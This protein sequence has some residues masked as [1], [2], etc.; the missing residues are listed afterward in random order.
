MQKSLIISLLLNIALLATVLYLYKHQP[1]KSMRDDKECV[2]SWNNCIKKL[3]MQADVVFFGDS[4]TAYGDWQRAFP[5][6]KSINL[7]YMGEDTK[8]MLRR[9]E[10][11][12]SVHPRKVFLMAGLNGLGDQTAD[13]FESAYCTLVDSIL[14]AV[15][16]AELYIENILPVN[17]DVYLNKKVIEA[18]RIIQKIA[19]ERKLTYVDLYSL[20]AVNCEQPTDATNDGVH[21]KSEAY[22]LWYE[23]LK[24][25]ISKR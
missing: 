24:E 22:D 12:Q 8:G 10:V 20:Y 18:N 16:D 25:L 6:I 3:D 13:G 2:M 1:N 19:E 4:H 7:G 21:L 15:P 17:D 9:V 11:I 14:S 23:S 5:E